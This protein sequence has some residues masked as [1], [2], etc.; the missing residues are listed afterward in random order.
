MSKKTINS[1]AEFEAWYNRQGII[2]Q[3]RLQRQAGFPVTEDNQAALQKAR[4]RQL[5]LPANAS[6]AEVIYHALHGIGKPTAKLEFNSNDELVDY[7]SGRDLDPGQDDGPPMARWN[8]HTG[9][10]GLSLNGIGAAA[11]EPA[12]YYVDINEIHTDPN[13]FQNRVD[14]FS[15]VSADQVAQTYDPN[16]FDPVVIWKDPAAGKTFMLSGHSRLEG[17]KRRGSPVI[18]A[19]YFVGTEAEAIQFARVDANRLAT[20]ESLVED[21]KAYKLMRD[22]DP[23]RGLGPVTKK[24]IT[25]A[26]KGKHSK[27]EAWSHLN[28]GGLFIEALGQENRS[29][30][31]HLETRA[32]W[33][34]NLRKENPEF[35]NQ[36][37]TDC[38]W[39]MYAPG[40]PAVIDKELFTA[41][42][43]KRLGWGKQR[44]FPEANPDGVHIPLKDLNLYGQNKVFYQELSKLKAEETE[45]KERLK[46]ESRTKKVYTEPEKERVLDV[47]RDIHEESKRLKRDLNLLEEA[48]SLFGVGNLAEQKADA[49]KRL[50][51]LQKDREAL[52]N[53]LKS[54]SLVLQVYTPG[55]REAIKAQMQNLDINIQAIKNSMG[56]FDRQ[57]SLW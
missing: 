44:L 19:R 40:A 21:L 8:G 52:A 39:F 27:L 20:A 37:E 26:F 32:T 22:G 14:A 48:P 3:F 11:G 5:G 56:L 38:F 50:G 46:T 16:R 36:H 41:E 25:Q 1:F 55:E 47:L 33:V 54:N 35:T 31:P 9:D 24:E 42:V 18:A 30:Y 57:R 7:F 29:Q 17:M 2:S 45:L 10:Y 23:A 13:R 15:E 49:Q 12:A 43:I 4:A 51:V 6:T 28:P 53:R 34:G